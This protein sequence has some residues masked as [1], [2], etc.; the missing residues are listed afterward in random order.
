MGVIN[1]TIFILGL[2]NPL[3]YLY[4]AFRGK[5]VPTASKHKIK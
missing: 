2:S 4:E 1:D 3:R 5:K